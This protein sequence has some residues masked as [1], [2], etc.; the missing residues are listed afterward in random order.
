MENASEDTAAQA[1]K[2]RG[3]PSGGSARRTVEN[4]NLLWRLYRDALGDTAR[5]DFR[6]LLEKKQVPYVTFLSHTRKDRRLDSL[7]SKHLLLYRDFFYLATDA[8]YDLSVE[9]K[10]EEK[11]LGPRPARVVHRRKKQD[12][13]P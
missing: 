11:A 3:R 2:R 6:S 12:V 9:A 13:A 10:R 8:R 4:G 1:P 7:P 5:A